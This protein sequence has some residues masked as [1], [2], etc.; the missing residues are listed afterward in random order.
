MAA[1]GPATFPP[2]EM[3]HVP[4]APAE[5]QLSALR[6]GRTVDVVRAVSIGV[7]RLATAR[8][9]PV[10]VNSRGGPETPIAVEILL[11]EFSGSRG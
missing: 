10:G 4:S 1:A 11:G 3:E 7:V 9:N 6:T 8:I 2:I 5:V